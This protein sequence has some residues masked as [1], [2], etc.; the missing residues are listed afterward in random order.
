[1][2]KE[3]AAIAN[4]KVRTANG[5]KRASCGGRECKRKYRLELPFHYHRACYA[6]TALYDPDRIQARRIKKQS[7][8][9]GS[10]LCTFTIQP[11]LDSRRSVWSPSGSS[12][13]VRP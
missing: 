4:R 9:M 12:R 11:S 13:T 10:S 1:M 3:D 5:A 7:S 8:V 2:V 6:R